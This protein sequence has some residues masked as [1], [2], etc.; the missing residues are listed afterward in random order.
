MGRTDPSGCSCSKCNPKTIDARVTVHVEG[1]GAVGHGVLIGEDQNGWSSKLGE[2]VT[3]DYFHGRRELKLD[4]LPEDG[5]DWADPLGQV[6]QEFAITT[7]PSRVRTC[8]RSRGIGILVKA[9]ICLR[10]EEHQRAKWSGPKTRHPWRRGGPSRQKT[11]GYACGGARRAHAWSRLGPS[12]RSRRRSIV[13]VG[14]HLSQALY[15]LIDN[16]DEPPG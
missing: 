3:H 7:P 5:G 15:N 2:N 1:A 10:S 4:S 9:E 13:E 14:G 8:L 6:T 11:W 16:H 12:G